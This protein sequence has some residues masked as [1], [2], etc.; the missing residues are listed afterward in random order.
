[1]HKD[2]LDLGR[3]DRARIVEAVRSR[4]RRNGAVL[5]VHGTDTLADTGQALLAAIPVP[6]VPIVLTGAMVPFVVDGSDGLQNV[7]E[8]LFACRLLAPGIYAVFHGRA[9]S[10]PGVV[11]DRHALT[12]VRRPDATIAERRP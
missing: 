10:F 12:F 11:K 7:T 6:A 8:A 3:Q 1:M 4:T 5:V 9:L 2:S